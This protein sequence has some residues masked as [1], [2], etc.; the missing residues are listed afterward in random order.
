MGIWKYVTVDDS[1]MACYLAELETA[2]GAALLVCMHGPGVDEFIRD[3]CERLASNGFNAVAPNF[4]HRQSEP[5]I[6]PWT[7][8]RDKQALRDMAAA[9]DEIAGLSNVDPRRLGVVGFCMGGRLAFL[10]A[11]NEPRLKASVIFHGG[12]IMIAKDDIA[13]PFEQASNIRAPMLGV[14]G[15][16]DENPSPADVE[17]IDFELARLGKE[18]HFISYDGAGHAFLNFTRPAVYREEQA[19]EAW[20][21]CVDW[22]D[23]H[24]TPSDT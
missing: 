4:Y 21:A 6:E 9:M 10:Y 20:K 8:M 17:K 7:K 5:L 22:L 2:N 18:H 24:L 1:R 23:Q 14:F 11:A 13:S 15:F 16:E 3:I 19:K 12:D